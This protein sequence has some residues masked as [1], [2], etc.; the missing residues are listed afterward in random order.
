[1][2]NRG[3]NISLKDFR[4]FLEIHGMKLIRTSGGHEVWSKAN[5]SRPVILQ[6][7][8]DPVPFFIVKN[9]LRTMGLTLEDLENYFRS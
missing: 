7:H 4:K 8:V 3:K 1:M 2:S 5:L 9:N 6:T